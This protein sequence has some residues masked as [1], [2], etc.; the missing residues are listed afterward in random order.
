MRD[1]PAIHFP[2]A[3]DSIEVLSDRGLRVVVR[4]R[5]GLGAESDDAFELVWE[6]VVGFLVRGDPFPLS[7][8]E[9]TLSEAGT[10]T[11]FL[12]MIRSDSATDPDYIDAMY[13]VLSLRP[14]EMR[15]WRIST[16]EAMI[17]VAATRAPMMQRLAREAEEIR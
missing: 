16:T 17:D 1:A 10:A 2:S 11:A 9:A 3:L 8:P 7:G 4:E 15:H 12:D 6:V 14:G 13:G 5:A